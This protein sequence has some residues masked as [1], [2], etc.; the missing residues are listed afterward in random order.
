MA[1]FF[2]G[3]LNYADP[4]FNQPIYIYSWIFVIICTIFAYIIW[5][6]SIWAGYK[7][8]WGLYYAFK[9]M[10]QAAFIFN[11][12]LISELL[13]ERDAKCIFDYSK[14]GYELPNSRIPVIGSKIQH[15]LFNYA[16]AFLNIDFAH[17]LL[18]KLGG[19]NMD[20]EIA[21]KFQ[22]Y[23][24]ES[25]SSVTTGGIHCDLIADLDDWSVK[26][27][28]QHAIIESTAEQH[29]DANPD[30]QIHS[31]P[32]FQ[33]KLLEGTLNCP[34]G[35]KKTVTIPWV[36]IDSAFPVIIANN[37]AAGSIREVALELERDEAAEFSKYYLKILFGC[38]GFAILLLLIRIITI[39]F[40]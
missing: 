5:R 2:G 32:K 4:L 28:P 26:T 21:K 12:G 25:E 38:F 10:S 14:W 16:S 17:A 13:S 33:R 36:R 7:S 3:I 27:S 24:W 39:K 37:E 35:I 8:V 18:Y 34:P 40:L 11:K 22:N 9:A 20:V 23:E 1:V 15:I 30:D 31:Y 6:F 19:R 29:N